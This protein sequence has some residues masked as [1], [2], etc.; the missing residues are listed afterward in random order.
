MLFIYTRASL[1]RNHPFSGQVEFVGRAA[2]VFRRGILPVHFLQHSFSQ[3][4]S[5]TLGTTGSIYPP[6]LTYA[7]CPFFRTSAYLGVQA[8][9]RHRLAPPSLSPSMVFILCATN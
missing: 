8:R 7:G 3:L 4:P 2:A 9:T 1:Y 6:K 5:E